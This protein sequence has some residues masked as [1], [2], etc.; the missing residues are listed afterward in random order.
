MI[1]GPTDD[2]MKAFMERMRKRQEDEDA[3]AEREAER[4]RKLLP[5]D[6]DSIRGQ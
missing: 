1:G 4:I 6:E 3:E 5:F 2:Q